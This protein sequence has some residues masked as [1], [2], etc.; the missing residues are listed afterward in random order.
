MRTLNIDELNEV[1]GSGIAG[2]WAYRLG[3]ALVNMYN[4]Y[5]ASQKADLDP[6]SYGS[7]DA[8]GYNAMG[9][10]SVMCTR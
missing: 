6:S 1:Q 4:F 9:A 10:S 8:S 2:K 7:V 5:S 3:E